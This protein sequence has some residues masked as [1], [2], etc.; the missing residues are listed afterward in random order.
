M[1]FVTLPL[2]HN[3]QQSLLI[4]GDTDTSLPYAVQLSLYLQCVILL[5]ATQ[6]DSQRIQHKSIPF[7]SGTI[8][9][10]AGQHG[11]FEVTI[12]QEGQ[13]AAPAALLQQTHFD[14]ILDTSP[15]PV[16]QPAPNGYIHHSETS[17]IKTIL[18]YL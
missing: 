9:C 4:I 3:P 10:I 8:Q 15:Q 5:P 12:E 11:E 13:L 18:D 14:L 6:R 17:V 1:S 16:L 2:N 7:C